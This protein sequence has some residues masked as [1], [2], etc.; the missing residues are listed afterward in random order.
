[1]KTWKIENLQQF[2]DSI[3]KFNENDLKKYL[4]NKEDYYG[5]EISIPKKNGRR[6][7]YSVDKNHKLYVIQKNVTANFL[8]NIKISDASCGFIRGSSYFQFLSIHSDFYKKRYYLRMDIKDF[9]GSITKDAIVKSLEYYCENENVDNEKILEYLAE[10]LTYK[11]KVIQ[12]VPSSPMLSNI[13]F[14]E[15]D[16]RI[17]RYCNKY[18]IRYSRYADDLLF[19]SIDNVVLKKSFGKGIAKILDSRGFKI[20]YEKMIR[21]NNFLSLNGFVVSDSIRLS[22]KKLSNI[23]RILF[24]LETKQNLDE[25]KKGNITPLNEHIKSELKI[26]EDRF[27][28]KYDLANYLNG[29][30]AFMINV[31][32]N[33]EDEEFIKKAKRIITRIENIVNIILV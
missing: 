28:G 26:E 8:N 9:F 3:V 19:S 16:I 30:R 20:N 2:L 1:M 15:L 22:R 11:N 14:R 17:I 23:N 12:G 25:V 21:S 13:V 24:F 5:D 10:I 18:N 32:K 31:I 33:T 29:V 7:V 6:I 4:S 27:S